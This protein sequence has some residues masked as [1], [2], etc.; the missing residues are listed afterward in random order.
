MFGAGG[1]GGAEPVSIDGAEGTFESERPG[2][3]P[4]VRGRLLNGGG[5]GGLESID[6]I[7]IR[8]LTSCGRRVGDG[9]DRAEPTAFR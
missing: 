8:P 5:G 3:A 1:G 2:S 7:D 9:G 6:A 4:A